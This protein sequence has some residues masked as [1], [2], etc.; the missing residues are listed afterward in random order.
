MIRAGIPNAGLEIK[1]NVTIF[2]VLLMEKVYLKELPE[3]FLKL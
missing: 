2:V 3:Q 1:G